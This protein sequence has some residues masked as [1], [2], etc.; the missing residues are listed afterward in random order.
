M[1]NRI[2]KTVKM[3]SRRILVLDILDRHPSLDTSYSKSAVGRRDK[4][5]NDT[6]LP[7]EWGCDGLGK[8]L[9]MIQNSG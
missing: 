3:Y 8:R 9:E 1:R 6:R 5:R 2:A 4:A 7:F